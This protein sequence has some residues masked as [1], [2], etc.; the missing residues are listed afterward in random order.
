MEQDNK[1]THY[2]V[3]FWGLGYFCAI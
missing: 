1:L 2:F 3:L